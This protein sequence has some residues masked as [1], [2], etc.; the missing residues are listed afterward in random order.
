[1]SVRSLSVASSLHVSKCMFS[2]VLYMN[3]LP[4]YNQRLCNCDWPT[5]FGVKTDY[6]PDQKAST[7]NVFPCL[8][9]FHAYKDQATP[10]DL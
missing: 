5:E 1:M 2:F 4:A 7:T 3:Y 6:K 9:V 10:L 8:H